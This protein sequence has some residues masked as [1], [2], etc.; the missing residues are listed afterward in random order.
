MESFESDSPQEQRFVRLFAQTQR[1]L[2]AYIVALV[3]DPNVAADLLQETNIVLWRR[4]AD[5]EEGMSFLAWARGIARRTVL[6]YRRSSAR[7]IATLDPQL[8]EE[9]ATRLSNI[10][11]EPI[12]R[13]EV[14]NECLR[15]LKDTDRQLIMARYEPGNSV[16]S[17]ADKL[18]RPVNS[19][20]QSLSRIRRV[21]ADCMER[22]VQAAQRCA[23]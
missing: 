9:L 4:F 7:Q 3:Y 22:N 1:A 18:S 17:M 19:V 6:N 23:D 2:H 15:K 11:E 14:L 12:S 21:L 13:L 8:L 10:A 5:Y 20:S 16:N